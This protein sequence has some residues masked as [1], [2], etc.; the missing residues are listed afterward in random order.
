[1][2]AVAVLEVEAA[3]AVEAEAVVAALFLL[4]ERLHLIHILLL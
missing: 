2:E 4:L 1:L 3:L